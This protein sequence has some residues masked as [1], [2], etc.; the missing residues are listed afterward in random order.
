MRLPEGKLVGAFR[1]QIKNSLDK[2][3]EEN[4]VQIRE[5]WRQAIKQREYFTKG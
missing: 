4:Q 2:E 3:A 1:G 5:G